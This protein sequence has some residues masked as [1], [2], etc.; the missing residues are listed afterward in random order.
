MLGIEADHTCQ[1]QIENAL[2][3]SATFVVGGDLVVVR[4][5]GCYSRIIA[6]ITQA[7]SPKIGEALAAIVTKRI[8]HNESP[9]A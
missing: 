1:V 7:T 5:G 6:P 9:S 3:E 4:P 2:Q 8:H